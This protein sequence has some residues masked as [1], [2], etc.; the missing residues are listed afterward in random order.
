[1]SCLVKMRAVREELSAN[2]KK[3]ADFILRNAALI[4]DYSS[5]NL[6]A[7]V[8]VSQSSIIKFSQK[9]NYRGFTDLKL[10]IHEAVV[11]NETDERPNETGQA[12]ETGTGSVP[13]SLYND[14]NEAL[15]TTMELNDEER[16]LAAVKVLEKSGRIQIVALGAGSLVARNFAS[17]LIQIG[18]SVIA[19]VDTYIQLSSIATL[20]PGDAVFVISYAGQSPKM[21]QITRQA[22]KAGTTVISLTNYNANPVRSLADIRLFCVNHEGSFQVPQ[23]ISSASQQHVVDVL[24]SWMLK[25]DRHARELLALSRKAVEAI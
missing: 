9:L 20:G 16:L 1:M 15:L 25:R 14:K 5:Q 6:A 23:I 13:Q 7:A 22:K 4:R 12:T 21:V 19:E 17:N 10:A 18:K 8:G 3:I 2:E 11:K 24:F